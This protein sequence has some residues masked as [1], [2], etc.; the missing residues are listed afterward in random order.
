[1]YIRQTTYFSILERSFSLVSVRLFLS[2]FVSVHPNRLSVSVRRF[3]PLSDSVGSPALPP[4]RS[5]RSVV[6]SRSVWSAGEMSARWAGV[7]QTG[8]GRLTA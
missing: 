3:S 4:T 8:R 2:T 5:R 7:F 1:M 6:H